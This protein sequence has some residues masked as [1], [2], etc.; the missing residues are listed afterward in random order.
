[1]RAD[2]LLGRFVEL[3]GR[4]SRTDLALEQVKRADVRHHGPHG[5]GH[6]KHILQVFAA[7]LRDG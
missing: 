2:E 1:M 6:A 5:L 3:G 4:D 7:E